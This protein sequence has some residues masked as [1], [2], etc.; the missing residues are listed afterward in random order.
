MPNTTVMTLEK[1]T[2]ALSDT[3]VPYA[4]SKIMTETYNVAAPFVCV[5]LHQNT[6]TA[7]TDTVVTTMMVKPSKRSFWSRTKKL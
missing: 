2:Q 7:I 3:F 6:D 5:N 1:E 4:K